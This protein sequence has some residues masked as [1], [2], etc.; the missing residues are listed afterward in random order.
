MVQNIKGMLY[1]KQ[2]EV[3]SA[4]TTAVTQF[5]ILTDEFS[6]NVIGDLRRL[7]RVLLT[8]ETGTLPEYIR[9]L[10][11]TRGY[12]KL[13]SEHLFLLCNCLERK[14]AEGTVALPTTNLEMLKKVA[15]YIR[16]GELTGVNAEGTPLEREG[17]MDMIQKHIHR[18][19]GRYI[20]KADGI[21]PVFRKINTVTQ[22][23]A[24]PYIMS[25]YF[26]HFSVPDDC[27]IYYFAPHLMTAAV[28]TSVLLG[29]TYE[30]ALQM[31][32][33]NPNGLFYKD[34]T[35]EE[36][37]KLIRAMAEGRFDRF[38]G[39]LSQAYNR[40]F[41]EKI[42]NT[43]EGA[44]TSVTNLYGYDIV[45]RCEAII[46]YYMCTTNKELRGQPGNEKN[47]LA[48]IFFCNTRMFAIAVQKDISIES[49]LPVNHKY[50]KKADVG[51]LEKI[52][53]DEI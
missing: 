37:D 26:S 41:N 19:N 15:M 34:S 53:F 7:I 51:S 10:Q 45:S 33:S 39:V 47:E 5:D 46:G 23:V 48:R 12:F 11:D 13:D 16:L 25:D 27:D 29:C 24:C 21:M 30:E 28:T 40:Y 36:T 8:T 2:C 9:Y 6:V 35:H 44:V 32:D 3:A 49:V 1:L 20:G 43:K 42:R 50:F 4:I 17:E 18:I 31:L 38:D 22:W 52:I 14:V